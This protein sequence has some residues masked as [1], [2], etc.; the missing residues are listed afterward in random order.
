MLYRVE[1]VRVGRTWQ[2]FQFDVDGRVVRIILLFVS[3]DGTWK[4]RGKENFLVEGETFGALM[5]RVGG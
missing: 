2:R 3:V 1:R 5:I 4:T